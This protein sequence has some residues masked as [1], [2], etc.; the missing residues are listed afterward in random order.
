MSKADILEQLP[1][2]QPAER[3]ELLDRLYDLCEQDLFDGERPS[4][5]EKALLDQELADYQ[6]D[7]SPGEPWEQ[8]EAR[9]RPP[10]R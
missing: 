2:L 8:V 1:K 9:L 6:K 5:A 4:P 10:P 7:R 3:R